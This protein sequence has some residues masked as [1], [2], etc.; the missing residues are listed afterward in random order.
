MF[1]WRDTS[2]NHKPRTTSIRS[3]HGILRAHSCPLDCEH[4][5]VHKDSPVPVCSYH[6]LVSG[7]TALNTPCV[8]PSHSHALFHLLLKNYYSQ[9]KP[10]LEVLVTWKKLSCLTSLHIKMFSPFWLKRSHLSTKNSAQKKLISVRKTINKGPNETKFQ[11]L[12]LFHG[13]D[14]GV[15][16]SCSATYRA[17]QGW[18]LRLS[19]F[20]HH[21]QI[22]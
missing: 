18:G 2:C 3:N 8:G 12:Y 17:G 1:T 11:A 13:N 19:V 6:A 5:G 21:L 16:T 10:D 4:R 15:A 14:L 20:L 7:V 22:K 9:W